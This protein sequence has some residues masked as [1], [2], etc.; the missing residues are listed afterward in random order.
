MRIPFFGARVARAQRQAGLNGGADSAARPHAEAPLDRLLEVLRVAAERFLRGG[1]QPEHEA[2][3]LGGLRRATDV[4][5]AHLTH[6]ESGDPRRQQNGGRFEEP[7]AAGSPSAMTSALRRLGARLPAGGSWAGSVAEL[8]ADVGA[9]L[10]ATGVGS[11][12]CATA[13]VGGRPWALLSVASADLDRP[14][15]AVEV[16]ALATAACILGAAEESEQARAALLASETRYRALVES[17]SD[18]IQST[19]ADGRIGFVNGAWATAL[20]W[21]RQEA[22]GMTMWEVVD[23]AEHEHYRQVLAAAFAGEGPVVVE[24]ILRSRSG[25]R[26]RVEGSVALQLDGRNPAAALAIFRNVTERQRLSRLKNDFVATVSHE[27]RTPL[28]SMLGA[29]ALLRSP[30]L[31]EQE[32]RRRELVDLAVRNGERLLRLVNELLDV[33]KLEA[34]RLHVD[35]V[36]TD[37]DALLDE[38][39]AAVEPLAVGKNV[40]VQVESDP[41]LRVRCDRER[42]V[43]ALSNV[44]SNA[45][46]FSPGGADVRVTARGTGE[47]VQI[48]V[49]DRGPGIPLDLRRRL[50]EPFTQADELTTRAAGGPGLG[51]FLARRLVEAMAGAIRIESGEGGT[52]AVVT[53]P[54]AGEPPAPAPP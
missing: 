25:E 49:L 29:L 44:L 3:L 9:F 8:D 24:T 33:Q 54:R 6:L 30:R 47:V 50:F 40:R 26:L 20:G 34:G 41:A 16:E 27:L 36:A 10:R 38:A 23:P 37:V 52:L 4:E 31:D 53:M 7:A 11:L 5:H 45:V 32:D 19:D 2:E 21:S 14:W 13:S 35:I 48:E 43:Q 28:T 42:L 51:L 39:G 46:K 22:V 18:L 12:A 1:P 17:A 15:S